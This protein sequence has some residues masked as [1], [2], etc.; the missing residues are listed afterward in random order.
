[1]QKTRP[2]DRP[3]HPTSPEQRHPAELH[4][5]RAAA[6]EVA[7]GLLAEPAAPAHIASSLRHLASASDEPA[8]PPAPWPRGA[9][10]PRTPSPRPTGPAAPPY[11]AARQS[12]P[13]YWTAVLRRL[14]RP[15]DVGTVEEPRLADIDSRLP[16]P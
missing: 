15:V 1:M 9:T 4:G 5:D 3:T 10:H 8:L 13:E 16:I 12:A 11:D 7:G 14:S 2:P 6:G